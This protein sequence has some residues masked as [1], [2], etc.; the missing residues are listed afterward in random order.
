MNEIKVDRILVE[1]G[2]GEVRAVACAGDEAWDIALERPLASAAASDIYW[3]RAGA[4]AQDGGRYFEIGGGVSGLARRP[5]AGWTDGAYGLV[6]VLRPAAG[7]KGPRLTDRVWLRDGSLEVSIGGGAGSMDDRVEISRVASKPERVR[8]REQILAALPADGAVRLSAIPASNLI[9]K[10]ESAFAK[11]QALTA[12]R[13]SPGRVFAAEGEV[14]WLAARWPDAEWVPADIATRAWVSG[15]ASPPAVITAPDSQAARRIDE[16][17]AE[18]LSPE[19]GLK[20][21]GR[22]WIEPTH[23]LVA[24][25]VDRAR[26]TGKGGEIN[27]TA[28]REIARQLR[29]RRL[30]GVIAVDFLREGLSEGLAVL[31][32]YASSDL[33]AWRPPQQ[34]DAV[35]LVCFQRTRAG[36]SLTEM[37]TGLEASGYATLRAVVR[38]ADQGATPQRIRASAD[39]VHLLQTDLAA[40]FAAA[41]TRIGRPLDLEREYGIGS[42]EVLGANDRVLVTI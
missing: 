34:S 39:L 41:V 1:A 14:G 21:G 26:H 42:I 7:G 3:A 12:G 16:V 4:P 37:A 28:A 30:G 31:G 19:A 33:L 24:I 9:G 6:Q 35:G 40:S 36:Q 38:A 32:E 27:R 25:D 15:L 11:L 2:P 13:R 5:R 8:A 18:A 17:T 23:A 29:L 22:V 20:G 10:T